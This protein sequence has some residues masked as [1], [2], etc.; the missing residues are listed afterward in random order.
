MLS[1]RLQQLGEKKVCIC[2]DFNAVRSAEER[3]SVNQGLRSYDQISFNR[4]IDDNDLVDLPL[5]G[6]RFT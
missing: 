6:R 5:C 2:G 4:F 1:G 3:R